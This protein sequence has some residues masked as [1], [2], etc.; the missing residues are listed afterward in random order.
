MTRVE[1][2]QELAQID[3]E[4]GANVGLLE[5]YLLACLSQLELNKHKTPSYDLF[6]MIFDRARG[7]PKMEFDASWRKTYDPAN[8]YIHADWHYATGW[9]S[10]MHE[11]RSLI[12]DLIHTREVRNRAGYQGPKMWP[13]EW[14]TEGGVRF[15][16]GTTPRSILGYAATRMEGEYLADAFQE[17]KV[18]WE[19]FTDP[20]WIGISYE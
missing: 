9:E 16:N 19:E 5:D 12:T 14:D 8:R 10:V 15:Y 6:L 17:R 3:F 18:D 13:G 7:G 2:D 4:E 1:F 11:L 20:I